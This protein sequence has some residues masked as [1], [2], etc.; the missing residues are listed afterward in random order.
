MIPI[1]LTIQGLYSYQE[2][3]T[4][5]FTR[6]TSANLFGIFGSVGSGKSSILEAITFAIYGE[7]DRMNS[8]DNRNYNMMNLKSNDLLIEFEFETGKNQ[9]AYQAVVKGRRNGKKFEEVKT[10]ERSAYLKDGGN[11]IPIETESLEKAIGLSYDNFKRT[12]IIPQGQFQEFLQ[13]G[14]KDRTQMM[15]E[16]FNL[17]RFELYYKVASLETKNN[18]NKQ[19]IEGQL[20]QLGAI[21]PEQVKQYEEQL[22]QLKTEIGQMGQ[23]LSGNQKQE[24]EWKQL[25]ELTRKLADAQLKLKQL[26]D[27]EPEFI[28]LEKLIRN[29]EQCLI[30]FKSL[31]DGLALSNQ[32]IIQ[33][34]GQ[35]EKEKVSLKK[36]EEEIA[37]S[38]KAFAELKIAYENRDLL[39]RQAEELA[40]I[41]RLNNLS[42]S[43]LTDEERIRNGK[44][45]LD[46]TIAKAEDLKKEKEA[47]ELSLNTEKSRLP[48]LAMLSDVKTWHIDNKYLN[49]QLAEKKLEIQKILKKIDTID[50]V[51]KTQFKNPVFTGMSADAHIPDGIQFLKVHQDQLKKQISELDHEIE[52]YRVQT[53][54]EEYAVNLHDGEACPLCGSLSHPVVLSANSVAEALLKALKSRKNIE[55]E[56]SGAIDLVSQLSDLSNRLKFNAEHLVGFTAKRKELEA[57]VADHTALFR[58]PDFKDE[59]AVTLAFSVADTIK[60][61][62]KEKEESLAKVLAQLEKEIQN[63]EK[64]Q[65][66]IE[67]IRTVRTI[68]QTEIHTLTE[69]I[70]LLKIENYRPRTS[71]EIEAEKQLLLQ[72]YA[73]LEKQFNELTIRLGELRRTKDTISGSLEANRTVFIQE[74]EYNAGLQKMLSVGLE[75]SEYSSIEEVKQILA[76]EMNLELQ[77]QKLVDFKHQLALLQSQ[78]GQLQNEIA[79]RTYDSE[80]HHKLLAEISAYTE[81]L[82]MKNKELGKAEELLNKLRKDLESQALLR[83]EMESLELR[84]ENIKT[85]KSLFKGS[86]FVNYISSVY[87][88]NL[89]NAANDRFFQLTRQK[90]SLEITGDNSFQVRDF[91]NGGKVRSV[92]TLS[93]GQTFQAALS[94]A[95]ALADNIQKIT[96]SNQNFFFLDEGFGSLDKDSLSVV[97]DTLKSL[98][99]E[100]RIVGVISHVEEMQQEIDTHLRIINHEENGSLILPSWE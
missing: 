12:I 90:L 43:V 76:Q 59:A 47:L 97:F 65:V 28:Q 35:I 80:A 7:T 60:K 26:K 24:A 55:K 99:K 46:K 75:K 41:V 82:N 66:E 34:T 3:Q 10:L 29:Y 9:T 54:L 33:K 67:K 15:K 86:G 19:N 84:G 92:K 13:L 93:G 68:S 83:K 63:K 16:L 87:L 32:K 30:Q 31:L 45:I 51:V 6:L 69:Q 72:K 58:W 94:L 57:K 17:E 79:N 11:W 20:Q 5:D 81:K 37:T 88:Q 52:H 95:L 64:F 18:S 78:V 42:A 25:Q 48:D 74:Q 53:K 38:E 8:R 50:E 40:K 22:T 61:L 21:D 77:K 23:I 39:K 89:C 62:L 56:I 71:A 98:R 70:Q 27:R 1:K 91:L 85:M 96:D 36:A 14:N 73:H 49:Q 44:L 100:N 4:I 2:K